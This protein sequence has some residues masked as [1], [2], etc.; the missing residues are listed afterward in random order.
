METCSVE[1]TVTKGRSPETLGFFWKKTGTRPSDLLVFLIACFIPPKCNR[2]VK[3]ISISADIDFSPLRTHI[4]SRRNLFIKKDNRY[5]N[6]LYT[7]KD[8]TKI[9]Y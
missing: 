8:T 3:T 9:L 4:F 1:E 5:E 2:S 6:M 7:L